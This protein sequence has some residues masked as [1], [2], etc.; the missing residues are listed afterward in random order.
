MVKQS[1]GALARALRAAGIASTD[2]VAEMMA[3][4]MIETGT[5]VQKEFE[6]KKEKIAMWN[7]GKEKSNEEQTVKKEIDK[8]EKIIE[9]R[10]KLNAFLTPPPQTPKPLEK[11][12]IEILAKQLPP[13]VE[14]EKKEEKEIKTFEELKELEKIEKHLEEKP[15]NI[16][17]EIKKKEDIG[18]IGK[19]VEIKQ[20]KQENEAELRKKFKLD[21]P[22]VDL[23]E[24]FNFSKK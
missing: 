15:K 20:Q 21:Q 11:E 7:I 2:V 12:K 22:K 9:E 8:N 14:E 10:K 1:I 6:E 4:S 18:D 19:S 3:R 16:E 23:T 13:E 17:I 5:K 24:I